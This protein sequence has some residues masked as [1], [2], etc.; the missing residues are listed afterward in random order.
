MEKHEKHLC[1]VLQHIR[2]RKLFGKLSKCS[3]YQKE[4]HYLGHIL[5]VDGVVVDPVKIKAILEWSVPQNVSE[6]WSF[7]GLLGYY[8]K[9]LE[10]F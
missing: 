5:L 10:G 1:I 4:I 9:F 7:M 6:V 2:E 8:R 3:F